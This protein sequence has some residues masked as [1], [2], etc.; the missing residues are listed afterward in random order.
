MALTG[1]TSAK[2]LATYDEP[3]IEQQQQI[4]NTIAASTSSNPDSSVTGDATPTQP[5]L[6]QAAATS[7]STLQAHAAFAQL[8]NFHPT[9]NNCNVSFHF[10]VQNKE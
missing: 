5:L 3:T 6:T 8:P 7:S 1:H 9:F 4:S 10:S 2:S